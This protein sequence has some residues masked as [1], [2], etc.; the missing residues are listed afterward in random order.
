MNE[1]LRVG[2]LFC[3][4]S[5]L[6]A[7]LKLVS[8]FSLLAGEVTTALCLGLVKVGG[9]GVVVLC[10]GLYGFASCKLILTSL[11][12]NLLFCNSIASLIAMV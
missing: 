12:K 5:C 10:F 11:S 4:E 7:R 9:S 2:L 1:S 8:I 6:A 3:G